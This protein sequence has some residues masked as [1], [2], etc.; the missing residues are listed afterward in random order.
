MTNEERRRRSGEAAAASRG[1]G[2]AAAAARRAIEK[3][4]IEARTGRTAVEDIRSLAK[5]ERTRQSLRPLAPVGA[6]PATRGRADYPAVG[7]GGAGTG[8]PLTEQPGTREYA[9][10]PVFVETFDGSGYFRVLVASKLTF[11][12][13][14]GAT[15]IMNLDV[16]DE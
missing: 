16:P 13:V 15:A 12:D 7:R 4:N 8:F 2:E 3:A 6:V 14:D 10:D 9:P 5:P 11:T 1:T